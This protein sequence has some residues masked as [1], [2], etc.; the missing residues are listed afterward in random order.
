VIQISRAN[1]SATKYEYGCDLRRLF[2]WDGVCDPIYWGGAI[3]HVRPGEATTW[4]SHDEMEV[5]LL[6]AGN[7]V[8]E[9]GDESEEVA[10]CDVILIPR[11][12]R[13]RIRNASESQ[14]LK[15]LSI[16]WDS[17]EARQA[18]LTSLRQH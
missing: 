12:S 8:I 10:E 9:I 11:N 3:A 17:P 13:H 1:N 4:D 15:F 16:F 5:F 14:P 18:M 6:I 2:P 7:G